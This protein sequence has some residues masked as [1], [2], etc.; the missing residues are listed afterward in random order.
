MSKIEK[1]AE[2]QSSTPQVPARLRVS[3]AAKANRGLIV[4]T[5]PGKWTQAILW[6]TAHSMSLSTGSGSMEQSTPASPP[7]ALR[8]VYAGV[9][10]HLEK[11][12]KSGEQPDLLYRWIAVS[13]PPYFTALALWEI[14]E[15]VGSVGCFL[16]EHTL[17]LS[18]NMDKSRLRQPTKGRLPKSLELVTEYDYNIWLRSEALQ[19]WEIVEKRVQKQDRRYN[20]FDLVIPLLWRKQYPQGRYDLYRLQG[21]RSRTNSYYLVDRKTRQ[22]RAV[23]DVAWAD[24]DQM[25]RLIFTR[26]GAL[27]LGELV[28]QEFHYVLLADFN[29]QKITEV[30]APEWARHW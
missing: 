8:C 30:I 26:E 7:M 27:W 6:H 21:D 5:G 18:D 16:D 10:Y 17:L 24:L 14:D 1:A 25:G 23:E 3:L 29:D 9:K 11:A 12:V 2:L 15:F 22:K 19:G 20:A 13:R 28:G 4:R